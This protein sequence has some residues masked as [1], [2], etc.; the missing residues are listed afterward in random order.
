VSDHI[1]VAR[2]V[3]EVLALD[4]TW[5]TLPLDHTHADLAFFLEVIDERQDAIRPHAV[6]VFEGGGP[7][8]LLAT[9]LETIRLHTTFG[10]RTVYSP[11]VR[12]LTVVP[13]G[14]V[15]SS[16]L[17]AQSLVQSLLE[18][19]RMREADVVIFPSMRRD[20]DLFAQLLRTV[21]PLRRSHFAEV[22]THRRLHLPATFDEFLAA[23]NRKV[24]A[25]VRYDSKRLEQRLRGRLRVQRFDRL[26]DLDAI[27]ADI[28]RV[29]ELTYQKGLD[30]AFLDTP[31]RRRLTRLCLE[32]GWFRAWVLY[33]EA[34]PIAF[35]QGTLYRR[36]YHSG[37]TGYDPAY[38]RDRVGIYLLMRV[39]AELCAE[40]GAD[41]FDFG[42]GDADYKRHFSDEAWSESDLVVFGPTL[43]AA[44]VN[45]TRTAVMG[46]A[47]EARRVLE[48]FGLAGRLKTQW[49]QR[50][51]GSA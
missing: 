39:I 11:R 15:A 42:F 22:R 35:W 12:A 14:Y 45:T 9:R 18:S 44:V 31:E 5:R 1:V 29:A 47:L 26:H 41:I 25:G 8:G 49:R 20:S 24:R 13:G 48:H 37:T 46:A 32:R 27:F 21:G 17:V 2:S 4:E 33:D 34:T 36:V 51:R 43:R 7:V 38:S 30:A 16:Q 6:V 23:R 10:Y 50:L 40:P 3:E 19:L 28:G